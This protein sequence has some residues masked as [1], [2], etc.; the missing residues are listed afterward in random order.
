MRCD[1][2]CELRYL[3]VP[4][5]RILL[6]MKRLTSFERVKKG[7]KLSVAEL[8]QFVSVLAKWESSCY[9]GGKI[10]PKLLD[11]EHFLS[12]FGFSGLAREMIAIGSAHPTGLIK[13]A[14]NRAHPN[15]TMKGGVVRDARL[16]IKYL[17]RVMALNDFRYNIGRYYGPGA[18]TGNRLFFNHSMID[19]FLNRLVGRG[20]LTIKERQVALSGPISWATWNEENPSEEPFKGLPASC[21]SSLIQASLGLRSDNLEVPV[22]LFVYERADVADLYRPTVTDAGLNTRFQPTP[23]YFTSYGYTDTFHAD[24]LSKT[25]PGLAE[26]DLPK[27]QPEVLHSQLLANSIIRVRRYS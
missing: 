17:A 15:Q 3:R 23:L 16:G 5:I 1:R 20:P 25:C 14:F 9:F 13:E 18:P 7:G 21:A 19:D 6:A 2:L 26:S 27:R 22:L 4:W 24:D 11:R 12:V 8:K 10:V